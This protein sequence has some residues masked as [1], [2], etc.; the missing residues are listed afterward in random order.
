[1]NIF[2]DIGFDIFLDK[3]PKV[4][5]QQKKNRYIGLHQNLKLP[6]TKGHSQQSEK[7]IQRT[8]ENICKPCI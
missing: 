3:T 8:E 2:Y 4:Y 5:R 6:Y 7:A 1:M